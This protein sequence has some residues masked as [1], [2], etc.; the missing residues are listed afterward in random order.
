MAALEAAVGVEASIDPDYR[1]R[2]TFIL[3]DENAIE[4][5][6]TLKWERARRSAQRDLEGIR[7]ALMDYRQ[8]FLESR[9]LSFNANI[10]K[11]WDALRKDS[12]SSFSHINI[13]PP[14]G[15]GFP[16]SFEL[17]ANLDDAETEVQVDVLKVFSESQVNALGVA[18]FVT[19]SK[20]LGHT[21]LVLDDP[22]QSMDED[23]F[24]TF[25]RDLI[26]E[27]L[28]DG[29]QII[30]LTHNDAFARDVSHYHY[31]RP[32][33]V[34]MSVRHS[35]KDGSVV[36]EGNRR[37]PERLKLAEHMV[38]A[39]KPSQAWRYIRLAVERLYTVTYIRYGPNKFNPAS[40]QYQTAEYM[41]NAGVDNIVKNRLPDCADRFKDILDMTAGGVHDT[42]PRGET[43][44]RDSVSFLRHA[45]N[46][47]RVGG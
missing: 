30:L 3:C 35:K 12:Y 11:V 1:L 16:V 32:D 14:S 18:A 33:Y 23:H 19:R 36:E 42:K 2:E 9:R 37:V 22:V 8:Q 29:F 13:P 7:T 39:G 4:I 25:A 46:D 45:L 24:I 28:D 10:K 34:T 20:L 40:W 15:K 27:V 21:M 44:I 38:D 26:S 41:W 31:G 47:L 6:E 5:F 43:D 17:K